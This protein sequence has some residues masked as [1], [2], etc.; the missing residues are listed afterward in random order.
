MELG[1]ELHGGR[2]RRGPVCMCVYVC[3]YVL[4]GGIEGNGGAFLP[5]RAASRLIGALVAP[6]PPLLKHVTDDKRKQH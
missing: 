6:L 1:R 3:V 4:G 5:S 2:M